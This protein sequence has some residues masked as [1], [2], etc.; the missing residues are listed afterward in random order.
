M[1]KTE[2]GLQAASKYNFDSWMLSTEWLSTRTTN[3]FYQYRVVCFSTGSMLLDDSDPKLLDSEDTRSMLFDEYSGPILLLRL[4]SFGMS[5]VCLFNL[6]FDISSQPYQRTSSLKNSGRLFS[7]TH[8]NLIIR[9]KFW[10]FIRSFCDL[11]G[12][13]FLYAYIV[14]ILAAYAHF[15]VFNQVKSDLI[16]SDLTLVYWHVC[17]YIWQQFLAMLRCQPIKHPRRSENFGFV[18]AKYRVS[19][20][21]TKPPHYFLGTNGA[22][23]L[24]DSPYDHASVKSNH[25][26]LIANKH[27]KFKPSSLLVS[28]YTPHSFAAVYPSIL[29]A[30]TSYPG[31]NIRT[32]TNGNSSS[33]ASESGHSVQS[34]NSS[35][36]VHYTSSSRESCPSVDDKSSGND[37]DDDGHGNGKKLDTLSKLQKDVGSKD[38]TK[39]DSSKIDATASNPTSLIGA[40]DVMHCD[41]MGD[42]LTS[43]NPSM[44]PPSGS[45][46]NWDSED[47]SSPI[48]P[49][50]SNHTGSLLSY[51]MTQVTCYH[52]AVNKVGKESLDTI[53]KS[54]DQTV[55]SADSL[56]FK[57]TRVATLVS[58]PNIYLPVESVH[59]IVRRMNATDI[60]SELSALRLDQT[61][62]LND[63]KGRLSTALSNHSNKYEA[64]STLFHFSPS[65]TQDS[66]QT[67]GPTDEKKEFKFSSSLP[68]YK[69]FLKSNSS[70]KLKPRGKRKKPANTD[71]Q[72]AIN[73]TGLATYINNLSMIDGQQLNNELAFLNLSTEGSAKA[74]RKRLRKRLVDP[75]PAGTINVDS[76]LEVLEKSI[77][78]IG[79]SM[80]KIQSEV[81]TLAALSLS[82]TNRKVQSPMISRSPLDD[83]V[84]QQLK[85][86]NQEASIL[87]EKTERTIVSLNEALKGVAI[88]KQD[89]ERWG[90]SVFKGQDSEKIKEI[91]EAVTKKQWD[92]LSN[93]TCNPEESV[94]KSQL[95]PKFPSDTRTNQSLPGLPG[96]L[97]A[98]DR[99]T[100]RRVCYREPA[101]RAKNPSR[102]KTH[103]S[104]FIRRRKHKVVLLT[105]SVMQA[106]RNDEFPSHYDVD[107]IVKSSITD[108]AAD[109]TTTAQEI[110]SKSPSAVYI[111]LGTRDIVNGLSPSQAVETLAQSVEKLLRETSQQCRIFL[112]H[113][114]TCQ[115]KGSEFQEFSKL[116]SWQISE[117]RHDENQAVFWNRVSQNRNANFKS[118]VG[119]V[120]SAMFIKEG[121]TNLSG[122]GIRVIMG[123]FRSSL[124][125]H[126]KIRR[127]LKRS[128]S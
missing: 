94:P 109:A 110:A 42:N 67:T 19:C 106:F 52:D 76:K 64:D 88:V 100:Y 51:R 14:P 16:H 68:T 13:I 93:Y 48:S 22:D 8:L 34:T 102:N 61:G 101:K 115:V 73:F 117:K 108:L 119:N 5:S 58:D 10:R 2:Q 46:L 122:R 71:D 89:L 24:S 114:V 113:P 21:C 38:D 97:H 60:K 90:E 47:A 28:S 80:E 55:S 124:H 6:V 127:H 37:G 83:S 1:M 18:S 85:K 41:V 35:S 96:S 65:S 3:L 57:K 49:Q 77:I 116:I 103:D 11:A 69:D 78:S 62:T 20:A 7:V 82:S 126:F 4:M 33:S 36:S 121:K 27:I 128:E 26:K 84:F 63:L 17:L 91:H 87:L 86:S 92:N 98:A 40:L 112:S 81:T 107:V 50:L 12:A 70:S 72:L 118:S 125:D 74:K 25:N 123:N 54:L 66:H 79:I 23:W 120:Q 75:A 15:I 44:T 56:D 53:L 39:L 104:R 29:P 32:G 45:T 9:I 30:S 59:L 31:S 111:H 43:T 95:T 99:E 105:D